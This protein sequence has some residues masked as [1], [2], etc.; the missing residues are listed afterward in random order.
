MEP[1]HGLRAESECYG[2]NML[3]KKLCR[4][5]YFL[6]E[7]PASI[8]RQT[9]V[10]HLFLNS[11]FIHAI[12]VLVPLTLLYRVNMTHDMIARIPSPTQNYKKRSAYNAYLF[13][14]SLE[15]EGFLICETF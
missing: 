11:F 5:R 10:G 1:L 13:C 6:I 4:F 15:D 12:C 8:C 3:L 2:I 14:S 7:F 9:L